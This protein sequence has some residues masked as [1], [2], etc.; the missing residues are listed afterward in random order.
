MF[1]RNNRMRYGAIEQHK[2]KADPASF[3][4]IFQNVNGYPSLMVG[5]SWHNGY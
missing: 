1:L 2:V 5:S 4:S 3:I